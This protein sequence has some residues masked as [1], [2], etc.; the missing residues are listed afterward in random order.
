[1]TID[2][3]L[4]VQAVTG[5][6]WPVVAAFSLYL[7]RRPIVELVG[8]LAKRARKVSVFDVS[9]ELAVLPELQPPWSVGNEDV[10]RL[11][12]SMIFDSGTQSLF[13][14]LLK[15]PRSDYAIV[16]VGLGREWLTSRLFIF[17]LILG[18][19]SRLRAFVFIESTANTRRRFLGVATPANVRRALGRRYPWFEESVVSAL[20]SQGPGVQSAADIPFVSKFNGWQSPVASSDPYTVSAFVRQFVANL[21]RT[22]DAPVDEQPSYLEIGAAPKIWERAQ[23]IDG[24]RLER[25]LVG[26][27]EYAWVDESL[28]SPRSAVSEAVARRNASFVAL[29]D[30]DRRFVGLV[31][32]F[33][34]LTQTSNSRNGG[35]FGERDVS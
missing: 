25:D 31:D 24:E 21:Q 27:L 28:D 26:V 29:V 7:L 13:E 1:M 20:S 34:L 17:S 14:E 33:A 3:E 32:R 19:V 12:S 2:W 4:V 5:L 16:D 18:E 11:T 15:P 10:R 8:Q 23:W 6:A 30:S 9:V 22:T 35:A